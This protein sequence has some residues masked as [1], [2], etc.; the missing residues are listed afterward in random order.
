MLTIMSTQST[1]PPCL[2]CLGC[3]LAS[4][5]YPFLS[6]LLDR[7]KDV[8]LELPSLGTSCEHIQLS[9]FFLHY[10]TKSTYQIHC[11]NNYGVC[12]RSKFNPRGNE[13]YY[14]LTGLYCTTATIVVF[15]KLEKILK[16]KK[17]H[18]AAIFVQSL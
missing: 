6:D 15:S 1:L 13:G 14:N 11:R 17:I 5:S 16:T 18:S 8:Q 3:K 2:I 9:A 7:G 10:P 12:E 4:S